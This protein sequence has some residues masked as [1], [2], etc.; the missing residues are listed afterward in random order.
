MGGVDGTLHKRFSKQAAR[1]AVRAK[2]G[3]LNNVV[4]LSGYVFGPAGRAPIAFSVIAEG[5]AAHE[6]RARID[7]LV[8]EAANELWGN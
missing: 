7:E 1:R 5:L 2:T 4:A 8:D 6:A 3:T